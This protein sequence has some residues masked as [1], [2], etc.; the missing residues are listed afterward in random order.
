MEISK[1]SLPRRIISLLLALAIMIGFVPLVDI[2]LTAFAESGITLDDTKDQSGENWTWDYKSKT[3]SLYNA[4]IHPT[5]TYH[6][7][8]YD[9]SNTLKINQIGYNLI[10]GGYIEADSIE[11]VGSGILDIQNWDS[12]RQMF[13]TKALTLS[14]GYITSSGSS[15]LA[16]T[17][18]VY[19]TSG[20]NADTITVSNCVLDL[21]NT[22]IAHTTDFTMNS[23]YVYTDCIT[24]NNAGAYNLN[25]GYLQANTINGVGQMK[26]EAAVVKAETWDPT[27]VRVTI[28]SGITINK[29]A[30]T[31]DYNISGDYSGTVPTSFSD[32]KAYY[33]NS[34]ATIDSLTIP[35]NTTVVCDGKLTVTNA[36]V[37]KGAT[38][39]ASD[40]QSSN[41]SE[42]NIN[43]CVISGNA[44]LQKTV[45]G[46]T[47]RLYL[48]GALTLNSDTTINN[49]SAVTIYS[50]TNTNSNILN[51]NN[52][53][54]DIWGD[55][56]I[57]KHDSNT[58]VLFNATEKNIQGIRQ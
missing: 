46:E 44:A 8:K 7:F 31:G 9:G 41:T 3:L 15:S 5:T 34:D 18:L 38:V 10:D 12:D 22:T 2:D 53:K 36:K 37:Y 45:I 6:A 33:F 54:F 55:L 48:T 29:V 47:G 14:N 28:G 23:G 17:N 35:E 49:R 11:V 20:T 42:N 4:Y 25:A 13:K 19:Y 30:S 56:S 40:I 57:K 43:G 24:V 21:P 58:N 52:H 39:Y 26:L 32:N 51:C 27:V 16:A 1:Q 50:K